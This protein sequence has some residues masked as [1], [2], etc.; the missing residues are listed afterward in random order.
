MN[1]Q[2]NATMSY[3]AADISTHAKKITFQSCFTIYSLSILQQEMKMLEDWRA[4]DFEA[5][6]QYCEGI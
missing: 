4:K 6:E 1:D 2:N 3:V 5:L